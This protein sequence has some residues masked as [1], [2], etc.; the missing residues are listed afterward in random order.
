MSNVTYTEARITPKGTLVVEGTLKDETHS[1]HVMGLPKTDFGYMR[2]MAHIIAVDTAPRSTMSNFLLGGG[3]VVGEKVLEC[4]KTLESHMVNVNFNVFDS[5]RADT[6][7][8]KHLRHLTLALTLVYL[9]RSKIRQ[10]DLGI[11]KEYAAKTWAP[12]TPPTEEMRALYTRLVSLAESKDREYGASWCKRGGIGA[13][14]TICRKFDR[15]ITQL[16]QKASNVWDVSDDVNST[17]CLEETIA[18]AIN[19]LLLIIEKRQV[20]LTS[21]TGK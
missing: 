10:R 11:D 7:L 17:E 6:L 20:I 9:V 3:K 14:F 2:N 15:L 1:S 13:W 4:M 18:D 19:Y 8:S 12:D 5:P 21:W 16:E